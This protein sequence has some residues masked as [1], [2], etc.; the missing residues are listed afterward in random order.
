MKDWFKGAARSALDAACRTRFARRLIMR[1][2]S[3]I[4]G[5]PWSA[6][7]VQDFVEGPCGAAYGIDSAPKLELVEQFRRAVGGISSGTSPL[8]H[9]VLAREIMSIPPETKGVIVECGAWK[10]ASSASLSLVCSLVGRKLLVCDSFQGLPG[11]GMT[12][13]KGMHTGVYGYYKEGMFAGSLEEV[14]ENIRCYGSLDSCEFVKGFFADSLTQLR[15]PV[16][17]AF[18]DVD[19]VASTRDCLRSL[20]PLLV[21]GA[22]I[23]TDDAGDL[24][25]V[26]V[27]FDDAWWR[28][29]IGAAAPGY[30]G[31]GCGLPLNPSCSSIGY[32]R[33]MQTFD[34]KRWKRAPFLHYPDDDA[35]TT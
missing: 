9:I 18:L 7:L 34:P 5:E 26:A 13:R 12:P 21:D 2:L 8:A 24:D 23:Y 11:D 20:W 1:E 27:F 30:V 22:Y 15:E 32:T 33:K 28:E 31:S 4:A 35:T 14:R 25:V 17:F 19:L 6:A 29:T 10:G 3:R 16:V